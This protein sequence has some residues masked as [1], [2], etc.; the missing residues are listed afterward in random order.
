MEKNARKG[1]NMKNLRKD[2][3]LNFVFK[4]SSMVISFLFIPIVLGILSKE[5][6]GVWTLVTSVIVWVSNFDVGIGNSLKNKIVESRVLKKHDL[7][8]EHIASSYLGIILI[9]VLIFIIGFITLYIFDVDKYIKIQEN[10]DLKTIIILNLFFICLN[11]ILSV[12]NSIFSGFE[13]TFLV[14]MNLFFYQVI[15]LVLTILFLRNYKGDKLLILTIIYGISM[16]LP[17]FI[18]TIIFFIRNKRYRITYKNIKLRRLKELLGTGLKIFILQLSGMILFYTDNWIISS[19]I[20]VEEVGE[21][22]IVNKL[23]IVFTIFF[24]ILLAPIW[25]AI[26]NSYTEKDFNSIEKLK[27]KIVKIYALIMIAVVIL[28]FLGQKII[29]YWTLGKIFPS[30]SL[31]FFTGISILLINFT[32]IYATILLGI[33]K[34]DEIM[35]INIIQAILNIYL[36]YIFIAKF[37]LG[38]TGVIIA[39]CICLSVNIYFYPHILKKFLK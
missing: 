30:F 11:F 32:N 9:A 14:S 25:P 16:I 36:S 19:F 5:E 26:T 2:I 10:I 39:T 38:S 33:G 34:V 28:I 1:K 4:V 17:I 15:S 21:Y 24:S 22:S 3:L 8:K 35:K 37:D 31:I 20:G 27:V 18:S 29:H 12:G 6:Y 23:F 13:K 7:I